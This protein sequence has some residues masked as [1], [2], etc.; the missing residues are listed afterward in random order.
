MSILHLWCL[1][2]PGPELDRLTGRAEALLSQG[3][4]LRYQ[5]MSSEGRARRFCLGRLLLREALS[6]HHSL[7]PEEFVFGE[8]ANGKL[9]LRH[10]Q[11]DGWDFCISHSRRETIVAVAKA[12]GAG[13]DIEE[14][15]R[16]QTVLKI[17]RRLYSAAERQQFEGQSEEAA[18]ELALSL[19]TLKE[20]VTKAVGRTIW[21][22]VGDT[23]FALA[24]AD[25]SWLTKPPLGRAEE[26]SLMLGRFRQQH[27]F[28]V[29]VWDESGNREPLAVEAHQLGVNGTVLGLFK[30]EA[31][32]KA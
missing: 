11:R 8:D 13:I 27:R 25:L 20:S 29:A 1:P 6:F 19:W 23:A 12:N 7:E 15:D 5:A 30:I 32:S 17:A 22:G 9:Y 2:E 28:A 26:W 18:A 4:G 10:P 14:G 21:Q 24:G 3:E 31:D 16:R